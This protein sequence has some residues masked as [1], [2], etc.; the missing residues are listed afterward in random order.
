M[1]QNSKQT[2]LTNYFI[3]ISGSTGNGDPSRSEQNSNET[4]DKGKKC[5][6]GCNTKKMN[7]GSYNHHIASKHPN[8]TGILTKSKPNEDV[9]F[10]PNG[11]AALSADYGCIEFLSEPR[12]FPISP[13][14]IPPIQPPSEVGIKKLRRTYTVKFIQETIGTYF[15][16]YS[17]IL[18]LTSLTSK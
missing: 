18:H 15:S 5:P 13:T 1:S 16:L 7:K 12:N 4:A 9:A 6:Y 11:L 3:K 8:V 14:V 2:A 17:F 10:E